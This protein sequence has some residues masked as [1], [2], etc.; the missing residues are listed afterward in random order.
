MVRIYLA[1]PWG[2]CKSS[3]D[4][5]LPELIDAIDSVVYDDR[6]EVVEPFATNFHLFNEDNPQWPIDMARA[7]VSLINSSDAVFANVNGCPPDEGVCWEC[8]Y[9]A[10]KNKPVFFFRDDFRKCTDNPIISVNLMLLA[11]LTEGTYV[12]DYWYSSIEDIYNENKALYKWLTAKL[13]QER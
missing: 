6:V 4:L 9:A 5:L 13:Q 11:H 8:G 1:N 3:N 7:N 2:F 12:K 10:G